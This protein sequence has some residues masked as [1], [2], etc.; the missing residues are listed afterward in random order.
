MVVI[1]VP[2]LGLE[3]KPRRITSDQ[4]VI[5]QVAFGLFTTTPP[6]PAPHTVSSE[7]SFLPK[8]WFSFLGPHCQGISANIY[9]MD[10]NY[11]YYCARS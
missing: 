4:F 1:D 9:L 6:L 10:L 7:N 8:D 11:E 5:L 3:P 2:A